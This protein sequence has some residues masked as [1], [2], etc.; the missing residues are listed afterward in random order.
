MKPDSEVLN[1]ESIKDILNAFRQARIIGEK[2]LEQGKINWES[3]A[4]VMI[5]FE[6]KLK[7]MGRVI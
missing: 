4:F 2:L 3:Y 5:I 7:S 1:M 6:V